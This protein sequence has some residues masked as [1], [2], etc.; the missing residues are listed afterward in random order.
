[1]RC[2]KMVSVSIKMIIKNSLNTFYTQP[3]L[4]LLK[5]YIC[6]VIMM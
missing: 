5:C 6:L 2:E 3:V 4:T 1:M